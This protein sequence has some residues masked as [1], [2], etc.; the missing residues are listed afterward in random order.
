MKPFDIAGCLTRM[1][2]DQWKSPEELESIQ[3]QKLKELIAY[4]SEFVPYY[5]KRLD[6]KR[7]N[8]LED[9]P[10]IDP[11]DKT[12]VRDE[13]PSFISSRYDQA[14]L[15]KGST[16]GSSGIQVP[17]FTSAAE[18]AYGVA[19]ECHHMTEVGV[20]PFDIQAR[21]THYK[22]APNLLQKLGFFR[23]EYLSVQDSEAELLK[24]LKTLRPDVL[25]AYPSILSTLSRINGLG[26]ARLALRHIFS[27]GEVLQQQARE[28][29][30]RSFSCRLFDRYGSMETSWIAWECEKGSMHLQSDFAIAEIVD[31]RGDPAKP[32]EI[33]EIVVTPLWGRAMPL[34]RY[35]LGDRV[36][37][38]GKCRCGRGLPVLRSIEGRSD[39]FIVLP[40]GRLRS[41]RSIN[42]MDDITG[43]LN[44]Q[45]MQE[46][47]DLFVF[48]FVPDDRGLTQEMRDEV[49][50]RIRRGCLDEQVAVE[51]VSVDS[52]QKGRTGKIATVV[53]KVKPDIA[54]C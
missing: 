20:R 12:T 33:G 23:S 54:I 5:R 19:F 15:V 41:A 42:L 18:S 6:G 39:D 16:S 7:I 30:S 43:M 2:I 34:I 47:P 8:G 27:G 53:S 22:S 1:K 11:L 52:I 28:S 4:A 48:R 44:Y 10:L 14:L 9:L 3:A 32:G 26:E 40:S 17:L 25:C 21:I 24:R 50:R 13:N 51:F 46:R 29:I 31:S 49:V 35:R 37:F 38:G 36:A 45:I